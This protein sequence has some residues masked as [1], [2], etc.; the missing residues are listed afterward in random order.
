MSIQPTCNLP[1]ENDYF[2]YVHHSTRSTDLDDLRQSELKM[3]YPDFENQQTYLD[4]GHYGHS[5]TAPQN[6]PLAV[7]LVVQLEPVCCLS[8]DFADVEVDE[9]QVDPLSGS[10]AQAPWTSTSGCACGFLLLRHVGGEVAGGGA[11]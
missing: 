9:R 3:N 2:T 10:D 11:D 6:L 5:L 4:N 7:F 1:R 8:T